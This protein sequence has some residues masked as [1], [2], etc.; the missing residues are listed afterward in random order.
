MCR[1][2]W[3]WYRSIQAG[4][5]GFAPRSAGEREGEQGDRRDGRQRRVV[6]GRVAGEREERGPGRSRPGPT[7]IVA[8]APRR[9]VPQE[10]ADAPRAPGP[11]GASAMTTA[12]GPSIVAAPEVISH[13]LGALGVDE[14]HLLEL[15]RRLEGG[16]VAEAA[17]G[18][19]TG[20]GRRAARRR[21]SSTSGSAASIAVSAA[22]AAARMPAASASPARRRAARA[23]SSSVAASVDENVLVITG[24]VD[25]PPADMTTSEARGQGGARHMDDRRRTGR[26]RGRAPR[27]RRRP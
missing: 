21:A 22:S 14:R 9:G 15:E 25:G 6:L 4:R 17:A 23:S 1:S 26:S 24:T 3:L 10:V 27:P 2:P 20:G 16:R 18:R 11:S 7:S 8:R 5:S 12:S 13:D 19:R